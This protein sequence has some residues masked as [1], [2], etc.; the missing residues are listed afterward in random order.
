M[1]NPAPPGSTCTYVHRYNIVYPFTYTKFR[2]FTRTIAP[3]TKP[4]F[5]SWPSPLL[6]AEDFAFLLDSKCFFKLEL[7]RFDAILVKFPAK[8]VLAYG[9]L[10]LPNKGSEESIFGE[11][12]LSMTEVK[13]SR[14]A[15][16]DNIPG[17]KSVRLERG[18][19]MQVMLVVYSCR[20]PTMAVIPGMGAK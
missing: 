10:Q 18:F 9:T 17:N 3:S 14:N 1:Q 6:P 11:R 12:F 13:A 16:R 8:C 19:C 2:I 15:I 4:P 20:F 7:G 5:S